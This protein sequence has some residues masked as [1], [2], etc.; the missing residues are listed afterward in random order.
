MI[1]NSRSPLEIDTRDPDEVGALMAEFAIRSIATMA[2]QN[3]LIRLPG[4]TP[5]LGASL[6]VKRL[7]SPLLL[8][9][10]ILAFQALLI[11]VTMFFARNVVIPEDSHIVL[12]QLLRP[13]IDYQGPHAKKLDDQPKSEFV[14]DED[15]ILYRAISKIKLE[16]L[17]DR[18]ESSQR[19]D[20]IKTAYSSSSSETALIDR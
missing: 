4:L 17:E 7:W 18:Q 3:R 20:L 10:G 5:K 8:V 9:I 19:L 1:S 2:S 13:V 12:G 6:Q 11:A 14:A 15:G 16:A